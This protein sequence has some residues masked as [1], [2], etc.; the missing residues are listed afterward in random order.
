MINIMKRF[1]ER[2]DSLLSQEYADDILDEYVL[3]D[4]DVPTSAE[5]TDNELAEIVHNESPPDIPT[6]SDDNED[7][8]KIVKP[9]SR[10]V[11]KALGTLKDYLLYTSE[12]T[13]L[14]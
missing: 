10:E 1:V 14:Q 12:T 4:E 9:S 3:V 11:A 13:S 7:D 8:M 5:L 2:L 6:G